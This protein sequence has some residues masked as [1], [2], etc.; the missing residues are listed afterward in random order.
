MIICDACG[1]S[2]TIQTGQKYHYVESGLST[3]YL[4]N[5]EVR[6]CEACDERSVR[7]K[8]LPE[9]HRCIARA[10]ALKPYPLTGAEARFLRRQLRLKA[11]EWAPMLRVD[12]STLSRWEKEEQAIGMQSDALIRLLYFR[13]LEEKNGVMV[14]DSI[15]GPMTSVSAK[16]TGIHPM[17]INMDDPASYH[18]L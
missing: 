12:V 14:T 6:V 11:K 5:A 17:N 1:G 4:E 10:I 2:T 18:F 7:I 8:A 9:L 3:V 16:S 13:I 15:I